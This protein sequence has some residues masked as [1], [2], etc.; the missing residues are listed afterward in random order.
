MF[1]EVV[2]LAMVLT[3]SSFTYKSN[4]EVYSLTV[5]VHNLRN[6]KGVIQFALYN[7]EGSIPDERYTKYYKKVIGEI[8][9]GS[10]SVTFVNLPSG[11][12]AVN[13]LHDEDKNGKI[14]KGLILPKEGIGFSNYKSIG[15]SN[16]PKFSKASFDLTSDMT[17]DVKIIYL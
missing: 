3:L 5:E 14:D 8:S 11:K 10:L 2:M 6:S 15:L 16:R 17:I 4:N 9:D 1:R 7:K 13:I 12:Y